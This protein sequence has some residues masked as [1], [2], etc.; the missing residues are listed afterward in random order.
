M[1]STI[2]NR[3]DILFLF[4]VANGN[5]NGD[6]DA[7]NMPRL[8]PNSSKGIISD[9][10]L[11]R[12]IRNYVEQFAPERG[13][14]SAN[15]YGIFIRQGPALERTIKAAVEK[16]DRDPEA[17]VRWLCREYF[18]IRAFGGV[19]STGD[20]VMKGSAYGQLRGPI[21]FTF[22]QSF[23]PITPLEVSI[24]RCVVAA[25]ADEKKERT[26]GNKYIVP[27]AL[28]AAKAY[29]SPVFAEK[30]GF[31]QA[32]LDLFFE[33]L[34]NMFEH[35]KSAARS[36][37]IVRGVYDFEHIGT[38]H[39][40]NEAQNRRESRLGCAHSHKLFEGIE[41]K[42][43]EGIEYPQSFNDYEIINHWDHTN[44]KSD[45]RDLPRGV[46]LHLKHDGRTL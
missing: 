7:G 25:V 40:N 30:T 46:K 35:D 28:Y 13:D 33:A 24:T 12:K 38:Q 44:A 34:L 18:D 39:P 14:A 45:K 6:P 32:D 15:G 41:V 8:D 1:N 22:G 10:C 17:A 9:V 29:V 20:A 27:Y 2:T 42:L 23:H 16:N 43:K 5:P 37:M 21:Q 11:K 26:M 31:N 4:D 19:L 36:E 3:H